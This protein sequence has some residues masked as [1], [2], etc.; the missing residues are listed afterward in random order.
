MISHISGIVDNIEG[1][2]V[3]I[4][5]NGVGYVVH[6]PSSYLAKPPKIGDKIKLYTFQVVR[7]DSIA[8]YGFPSKGERRL[9]TTLISVSGIGPKG[10]LTI[11]SE[12]PTDKLITAIVNGNVDLI[13]S[14]RGV[15]R[16]TA[17]RLVIE[18]KEKVAKAYAIEPSKDG[19]GM[20][21][22]DQAVKDSVSALM[23]LGYSSAEAKKA[24]DKA[25][26][27]LSEKPKAEEIIKKALSSL[28]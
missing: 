16:K 12:I 25:G 27:D 10:A 6:T 1:N 14:V 7:E 21:N 18:L 15:G 23:T 22:E 17:E 4:D 26:I 8:L 28:A 11:I 3:I 13:S 9:F 24:I 20:L 2:Q 19:S 5:V